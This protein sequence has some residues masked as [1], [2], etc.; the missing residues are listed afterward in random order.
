MQHV[1][2]KQLKKRDEVLAVVKARIL[3]TNSCSVTLTKKDQC[4]I[5]G[6]LALIDMLGSSVKV[7]VLETITFQI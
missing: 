1:L 4:A 3:T 7:G 6:V 2:V 5:R